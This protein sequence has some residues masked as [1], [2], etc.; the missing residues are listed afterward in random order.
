MSGSSSSP[1]TGVTLRR[2][3]F[4]IRFCSAC[5]MRGSTSTAK[6][7]AAVRAARSAKQPGPP[8]GEGAGPRADVADDLPRGESQRFQHLDGFL[9]LR[10]LGFLH[11]RDVRVYVLGIPVLAVAVIVARHERSESARASS[12][13]EA[14]TLLSVTRASGRPCR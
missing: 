7:C 6:T 12:R 13:G 11:P 9:P 1:R 10:P 8:P 5:K 3:D 4:A 2:P 14:T